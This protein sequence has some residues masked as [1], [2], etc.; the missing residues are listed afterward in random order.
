MIDTFKAETYRSHH[1]G[2]R[3]H[4]AREHRTAPTEAKTEP[5]HLIK[6]LTNK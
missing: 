5:K 4:H 1:Q 2:Q 3:N 6:P